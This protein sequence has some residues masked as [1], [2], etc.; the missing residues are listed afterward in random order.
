MSAQA[1]LAGLFEPTDA[2]KWSKKILWSPVPVHTLPTVL[3]NIL[4]PR[5]D[6]RCPKYDEMYDWYIMKSKEAKK[7]YKKYGKLFKEWQKK[8]GQK[9]KHIEHVFSIYKKFLGEKKQGKPLV[10]SYNSYIF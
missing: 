2:E 4:R 9:I 1:N 5:Y 6:G 8:I 10:K 3:D 7:M